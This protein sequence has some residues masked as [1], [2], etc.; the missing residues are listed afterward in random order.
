VSGR[1]VGK[2]A[3]MRP[4]A[5]SWAVDPPAQTVWGGTIEKGSGL[6]PGQLSAI[7]WG[8][9]E[10]KSVRGRVSFL[11][12]M[13]QKLQFL[14]WSKSTKTKSGAIH[15]PESFVQLPTRNRE[16]RHPIMLLD[17]TNAFF[18]A[19]DIYRL[20]IVYLSYKDVWMGWM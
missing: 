14:P 8:T 6:G 5:T 10:T 3:A 13:Q 1:G 11:L 17:N 7:F 15:G 9:A 18:Y 4:R 20:S 19:R 16:R 2:G 12:E